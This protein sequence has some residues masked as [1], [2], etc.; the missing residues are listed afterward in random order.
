VRSTLFYIPH[1]AFGWPVFGFG[2]LLLAW[3]LLCCV[4]LAMLVRRQGWN[5]DTL[6]YLPFMA[7]VAGAIAFLLPGMEEVAGGGSRLGLPIRGFGVMLMLATVASVGL[8]SYRAWQ[9]GL[10]PEVI[11]T[12][13]FWMFIAGIA[14]ARTFYIIEYWKEFQQ[15][16]LLATLQAIA[17]VTRGGLVVYG[18]VLAGLPAGIYF[19]RRR[20][21]PILA[22]ADVIAPSMV[23]GLALGRMGC[24]LNGCCFGG[25]CVD[26]PQAMTFPAG[27]PPYLQ[28]LQEGWRSGV[29]LS[30]GEKRTDGE[31]I[32]NGEKPTA[33]VVDY[34][35]PGG[36]AEQAG[37][38]AGNVVT[39]I[40]GAAVRSL[41]SARQQLSEPTHSYEFAT[42]DGR[43]LRWTIDAPPLRSVPVHPAQLYAAID[44]G[45][46]A[47]FLWFFFPF[48]RRDGEVF[49]LLIT[50]H[51]ISRFVLETIRSD[52]PGQFGT[53]WTISQWLSVAILACACALWAYIERQR[54]GSALPLV[55][56]LNEQAIGHD[57]RQPAQV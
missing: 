33:A 22:M 4:M 15:P 21:L 18:S 54:R 34:V 31:K 14:G 51:P 11:Y 47:M 30:S 13:A 26:Q 37:L 52:E 32:A 38:K 57:A 42:A 48:R 44:A 10:D 8:A 35:L 6:G 40:N 55:R 20:G 36:P 12:L 19:L 45:L 29:W 16:T 53:N 17:N 41:A 9:M 2:W 49:A 39:S 23:V 43:I 50:L 7:I 46:L 27:S 5:H 3:L 25:V 24:F 1:E 56:P 28:Q